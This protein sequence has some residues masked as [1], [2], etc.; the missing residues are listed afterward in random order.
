MAP[1][2]A[3]GWST[4]SMGPPRLSKLSSDAAAYAGDPRAE[5]SIGRLESVQND[6][7]GWGESKLS[8]G[9]GGYV[10]GPSNPLITSAVLMALMALGRRQSDV[11]ARGIAYLEASQ[12]SDGLWYDRDRSGVVFP[13]ESYTSYHLAATCG[14]IVSIRRA[15]L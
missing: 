4:I 8:Y 9:T 5:R 13:G 11:V 15:Q 7:G 2:A 12:E 3:A 14:A 6:D 1:G 10:P